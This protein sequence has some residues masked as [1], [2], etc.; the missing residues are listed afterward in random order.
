MTRRPVRHCWRG[1]FARLAVAG[2]IALSLAGCQGVGG[3]MARTRITLSESDG[4]SPAQVLADGKGYYAA[5][6]YGKAQASFQRAVELQPENGEAWLG[7]AAAYDELRR[8]DL[9]DRAYVEAIRRLGD[10]PEI[11][12]NIGY[13][14]LLR[15]DVAVAVQNFRKAEELSP[16][17]PTVANNMAMIRKVLQ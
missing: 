14:H 16:G 2:A 9:A 12:N 15:G 5:G 11:Y 8:F 13:S 1:T 17:N 10:R 3:L 7:L 6:E 4:H